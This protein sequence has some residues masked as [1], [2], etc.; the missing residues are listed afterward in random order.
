M[1]YKN[2]KEIKALI[3]QLRVIL[4]RNPEHNRKSTVIYKQISLKD[5]NRII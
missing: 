4:K 5:I 2:K 3:K 1:K